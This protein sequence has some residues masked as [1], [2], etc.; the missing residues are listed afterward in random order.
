[1]ANGDNSIPEHH[2]PVRHI[3]NEAHGNSNNGF[4][5]NF[6]LAK[7][8][9]NAY[10][11]MEGDWGGQIYLVCPIKMIKCDEEQL[12]K[13]LLDL[14]SIAWPGNDGGYGIYYEKHNP[15][16]IIAGGMGGGIATET[17]WVHD[18]FK[19]KKL[20][21]QIFEVISGERKEIER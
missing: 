21:E 11:I 12:K 15:G 13:L 2:S 14:D 7:E 5:G 20:K 10:V 4:L 16:D 9:P 6:N 8:T 1:M 17:L 19:E 18:E 3:L